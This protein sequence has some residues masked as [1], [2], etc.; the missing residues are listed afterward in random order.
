MHANGR[1]LLQHAYVVTDL[2]Q[3]VQDWVRLAGVGP[4][5]VAEG[6]RLPGVWYRG[7]T[8][9]AELTFAVGYSGNVQIEL[10]QVSPTMPGIYR[11]TCGSEGGYHHAWMACDDFDAALQDL[12]QQGLEI[13]YSGAVEGNSRFCYLDARRTLGTFIELME[14]APE[15]RAA[16]QR[17]EQ[18]AVGWDGVDPLRSMGA[19]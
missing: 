18:S 14:P 17:M 12:Q 9:D 2:Q 13:A 19:A 11:E 5:Y 3:S 7:T 1:R 10:I 15:I 6:L 16:L 8:Q 4:F